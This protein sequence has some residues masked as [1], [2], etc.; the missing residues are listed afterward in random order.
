MASFTFV[1]RHFVGQYFHTVTTAIYFNRQQEHHLPYSCPHL[2]KPFVGMELRQSI[3]SQ[4][5]N[6]LV[7]PCRAFLLPMDIVTLPYPNLSKTP[8]YVY[9]G[10]GLETGPWQQVDLSDIFDS[11]FGGG[12]GGGGRQQRRQGPVRGKYASVTCTV[13]SS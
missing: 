5:L 1:P 3:C 11:F 13:C 6:N 12:M 8:L 9:R 7:S 10:M 2:S 4:R